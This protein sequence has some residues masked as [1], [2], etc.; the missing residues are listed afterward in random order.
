MAATK[1][2]K[3]LLGCGGL[4]VL[5]ILLGLTGAL[6]PDP[7]TEVVQEDSNNIPYEDVSS[8]DAGFDRQILIDPR[9]VNEADMLALGKQLTKENEAEG[10]VFISIYSDQRAVDVRDKA[11]LMTATAEE[12]AIY[13]KY[14]VGQ[15]NKN[16]SNNFEVYNVH[17]DGL[18][19]ESNVTYEPADLR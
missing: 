9:Y 2:K 16:T 18:T 19:G 8:T 1:L 7:T 5:F 4:F 14:Y 15:Y 12:D 11:I 6:D 13:D 17:V 10:Y 3:G